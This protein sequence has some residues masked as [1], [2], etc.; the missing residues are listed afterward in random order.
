MLPTPSP[1][2]PSHSTND[3]VVMLFHNASNNNNKQPTWRSQVLPMMM[4]D[5]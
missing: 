5:G 3:D 2:L 4:D 1:S